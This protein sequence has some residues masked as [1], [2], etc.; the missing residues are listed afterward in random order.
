MR[1]PFHFYAHQD[2]PEAGPSGMPS[3]EMGERGPKWSPFYEC[4]FFKHE[5]SFLNMSVPFPF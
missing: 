1:V 4:S 3:N 2:D 5:G